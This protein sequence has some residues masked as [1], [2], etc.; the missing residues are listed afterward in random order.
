[1]LGKH[2]ID[3]SRSIP[4]ST[5]VSPLVIFLLFIYKLQALKRVV[6]FDQRTQPYKPSYED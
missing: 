1:M 4:V 3:G 6:Y 2:Y 5:E